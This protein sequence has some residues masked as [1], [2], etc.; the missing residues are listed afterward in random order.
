MVDLIQQVFIS[1]MID[2]F[3]FLK[4]TNFFASCSFVS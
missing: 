3:L 1:K 4:M 2:Q